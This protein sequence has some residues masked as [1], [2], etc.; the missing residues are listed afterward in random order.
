MRA[1][2]AIS[3]VGILC[4]AGC[5]ETL[6]V[7]SEPPGATVYLDDV[8]AGETPLVYATKNVRPLSYRIEKVGYPPA[9]GSVTTRLARGRVVGAVFTLGI[10]AI[11]RPLRVFVPR[12]IDAYLGPDIEPTAR[13]NLYNRDDASVIAGECQIHTGNCW[14]ELADGQR[15]EGELVRQT[16]A[17]TSVQGERA[18]AVYS[19]GRSVESAET[20]AAT[21]VENMNQAAAAFRCPGWIAEC[22]LV[23]GAFTAQGYGECTDSAGKQYKLM[24]RPKQGSEP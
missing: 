2:V 22:T 9:T 24:M 5:S 18:Q 19:S 20:A 14:V 12:E 10:V 17:I 3:V 21:Q 4:A 23:T 8:E 11:A 13:I 1:S 7:R 16:K 15:C 6:T